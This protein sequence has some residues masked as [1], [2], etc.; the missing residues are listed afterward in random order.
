[1]TGIKIIR[2]AGLPPPDGRGRGNP[3]G[4]KGAPGKLKRNYPFAKLAVGDAFDVPI[5]EPP[6]MRP[7]YP[8]ERRLSA[9]VSNRNRAAAPKFVC[10]LLPDHSAVRV[11]RVK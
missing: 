7:F 10:R 4:N 8:E 9:A 11:S 3:T 1:M 6:V 2:N 5:T